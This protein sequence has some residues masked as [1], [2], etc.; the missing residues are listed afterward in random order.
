MDKVI[1]A[2]YGS[3]LLKER[4]LVYIKGGEFEGKNYK[5]CKDKTEPVNLGW[6]YVPHRLYFAK[7]SSKWDNQGVAF[8]KCEKEDNPEYHAV[9]RLW[10]ITES[11]FED[12]H[13]QEGKSWYDKVLFLGEKN[14][15]PIKTITGCWMN[16][17]NEPSERYLNVIRKGLKE[18]T[19]WD[20][21]RINHYLVKFIK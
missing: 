2:A 4:F 17:I 6:M 10:E 8:L 16:E 19:G 3:N 1:Y 11:Q 12:I 18:T 9:V 20:D 14:G 21:D 15:L 5:G 13:E 7:R